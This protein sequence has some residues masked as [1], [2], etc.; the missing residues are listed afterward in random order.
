M[1]EIF[2]RLRLPFCYRRFGC[3]LEKEMRA[4]LEMHSLNQPDCTTHRRQQSIRVPLRL[5]T[6]IPLRLIDAGN[7]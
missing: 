4:H 3:E 7:G 1:S 5:R 6:K 2:R